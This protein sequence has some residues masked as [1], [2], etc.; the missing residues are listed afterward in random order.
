MS[1]TPEPVPQARAP[2]FFA[3]GALDALTPQLRS[4]LMRRGAEHRSGLELE[5]SAVIERVR[6]EGDGALREFAAR[7]DGVEL[8][9][10]EVPR[11]ACVRALDALAPPIRTALDLA[12]SNLSAFHRAQM[13]RP[14]DFEVAPGVRLRRLAQPVSRAGV[15][16]PGG[17]AAYPS[18]VLMGV[19]PARVAGV[20]EVLV[21][22]PPTPEGQPAEVVL[23]ASALA[24]ADRVFALGGAG[25]IAALTFGTATVPRVDRIVGPGNAWVTEAKRQVS[26]RVGVDCPAG[27]SE[28]LIIADASADPTL[29]AA[30][31]AAQA[32]HDP[33]AAAV[34][35]TTVPAHMDAVGRVLTE[36]MA[37]Q[38]RAS[39]IRGAL[40][41]NGA[42][43]HAQSVDE[44]VR[45]ANEYA[46]EH[47]LLFIEDPARLL[48]QV[49]SAGAVFAGSASSVVFGDYI[50]GAN[51]VLPTAGMSR[52]FSGL[53]SHDFLRWITVQEIAD[54]AAARLAE[55]TAVL[56]IAEGLPGHAHAARLRANPA[57]ATPKSAGPVSVPASRG[58]AAHTTRDSTPIAPRAREAYREVRTYDPGRQ[59]CAIDLSDNTNLF[60]ACPAARAVMAAL[61]D[62]AITRYPSVYADQLKA[63]VAR[64]FNIP[65]ARVTTGCGSD[66]LID[67]AVRAFCEPGDAI[68]FPLPTFGAVPMF[69]RMNAIVP[70]PVALRPDL[71][72]DVEPLLQ[73]RA[74][75]LYLCSPNNPTGHAFDRPDVIHLIHNFE[76]VI[77][78]DEAYADF[79]DADFVADAM[80]SRNTIILRTLSKAAGLAGLRVG[81][82]MGPASLIAEIEKS[83]GPYKVSH[84]AELAA[85]AVLEHGRDWMRD[86]VTQVRVTRERLTHELNELGQQVLPSEAN[87]VLVRLPPGT[88]AVDAARQLHALGVGVRPFPALH[89][90][91][92]CIRITVGPW[93]MMQA[94][95]SAFS[96]VLE[97][98]VAEIC[99]S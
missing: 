70:Q 96:T 78:L 67:S 2:V 35:I 82:A 79:A 19:I 86:T 54:A 53:G 4:R 26:G 51:H 44:A 71:R 5:V 93:P 65:T 12:A 8:E 20:S 7:F 1:A 92:D 57:G 64:Q 76:G 58:K 10:L 95:L 40:A 45:F 60:G 74:R 69:A 61:P 33:G 22:S 13:P 27:P 49:R 72:L 21:C 11:R 98:R 23:A 88:S 37:E 31:L 99:T 94:F 24:G 28:V 41:A 91:G 47:L 36:M 68:A 18:S 38:P 66:D 34:L 42:L 83:R 14:V 25:A 46:P 55:P 62:A 87:F 32:E 97:G 75:A 52:S 56:A 17:L 89:G 3:T 9:D 73:S 39:I 43:L 30:E 29:I 77:L 81:F 16:A 50:T 6:S 84:A 63:A 80:E 48:A 90:L 85:L 59:P 15:Y